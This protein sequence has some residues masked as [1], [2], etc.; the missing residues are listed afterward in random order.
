MK[1]T[2]DIDDDWPE[3]RIRA[4]ADDGSNDAEYDLLCEVGDAVTTAMREAG[5][6]MTALDA[7]VARRADGEWLNS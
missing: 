7:L 1:L 2:I 4:G 5:M 3:K 6:D